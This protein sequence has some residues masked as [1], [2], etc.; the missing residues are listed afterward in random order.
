MKHVLV[1]S[2]YELWKVKPNQHWYWI[3]LNINTLS[4][5]MEE[6][7]TQQLY[8]NFCTGKNLLCRGWKYLSG[9]E[10]QKWLLKENT[11]IKIVCYTPCEN[12][13]ELS[14]LTL[15]LS[16]IFSYL[17]SAR[18]LWRNDKKWVEFDYLLRIKS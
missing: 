4:F 1:I 6:I 10:Q 5:M 2:V 13:E 3:P 17:G 9:R 7:Y 18:S 15:L 12:V 8:L 14:E 16:L 11:D